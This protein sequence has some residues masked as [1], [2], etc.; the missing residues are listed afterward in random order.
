VITLFWVEHATGTSYV[1]LDEFPYPCQKL[2]WSY[3][4]VGDTVPRPFSAGRYDT[5]RS[6]DVMTIDVEG[7]IV[8]NTTTE[9]WN[10]RKALVAVVLPAKA[11]IPSINRHSAIK[12][13]L[14]GDSEIYW[15]EVQLTSYSIP[16]AA[17]GSPT[18]SPFMFSWECNFA[19]WY[20]QSTGEAV[21]L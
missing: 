14:D 16:L 17:S 21:L 9:Y 3:P 7:E 20:A 2:E 10:A 18:V 1:A 6:V 13:Q 12:M 5:R 4:I 8:T 15:A 19:Y 11:Q